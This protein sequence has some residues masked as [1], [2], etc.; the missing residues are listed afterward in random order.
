MKQKTFNIIAIVVFVIIVVIH[1]IRAIF[2]WNDQIGEVV[3]P[4]WSNGVTIVIF[5]YFVYAGIRLVKK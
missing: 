1:L 2:G 3:M 5:V 4:L